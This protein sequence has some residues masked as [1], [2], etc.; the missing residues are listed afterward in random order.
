M[1]FGPAE[2][3][4]AQS[5]GVASIRNGEVIDASGAPVSNAAEKK[6][7]TWLTDLTGTVNQRNQFL[8]AVNESA[9][10]GQILVIDR[11]VRVDVTGGNEIYIP[12]GFKARFIG[13]GRIEGLWDTNP[14][15]IALHSN[16]EISD[17]DVLY[18][19]P[20]LDASINYSASPGQDP[21][22]AV[23]GRM[24]TVM[25]T[26]YGNTFSGAGN[27][28]WYGPHPFMSCFCLMGQAVAK[29]SGKSKFRVA[30]STT[31]DKFI[32]WAIA[33]KGQWRPGVTGITT[34]TSTITPDA[35]VVQ[36]KCYIDSLMLDGVL[37]G[38][39]GEFLTLDIDKTR[40]YRYSD[41]QGA[42]GSNL[43]GAP[44]GNSF[45][46]P[47]LFYIN[48]R[49]DSINITNTIDYGIWV[50][51]N[52][53]PRARR[54]PAVGSCCSLKIGA[55]RGGV[56]G[57]KCF[58]P[59][60][61]ADLLGDVSGYGRSGYTIENFY[62]EYDS[63]ICSSQYPAIR[64]PSG[65][66][67]DTVIRS[68]K[69]V[70]LAAQTT[71]NVLG[72]STDT[73]CKRI[74]IKDVEI[75]MNDFGGTS[76]PGT[77]FAGSDH[78]IDVRYRLKAHTQTQTARGVIAYQGGAGTSIARSR[79]RA[80]VIGWRSFTSDVNGLRN[81]VIMDGGSGGVNGN[82]NVA[83]LVDVTN[84]HTA[85]QSGGFK[86]ERW[87]QS[88]VV[89]CAPGSSITT[90]LKIPANWS[91]VELATG[92]KVALGTTG[93]LTGFTVGWSGTPAGLGSVTGVSTSSRVTSTTTVASTGADR[94]IVITATGGTFDSTGSIDLVFTC[95]L[96]SLG[97]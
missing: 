68:G 47:H 75:E 86:R 91:V 77:Y 17:I 66:Y 5:M 72:S 51:N 38:V 81:R 70:D 35:K 92:P 90:A 29:F 13:N 71:I 18:L 16:F 19:G 73:N 8:T 76:Y 62:A 40:S 7:S 85:T 20:G 94:T 93:G 45:P 32:P 63:T 49:N 11:P 89:P 48:E 55:Q 14:L 34:S 59:D 83:E 6:V 39:Q 67:I 52:V 30:E 87:T 64:F 3:A 44:S 42:D 33:G 1:R 27:A 61:F 28:L 56:N 2:L 22:F 46:P 74:T 9:A 78:S 12:D 25:Q 65:P 60:G 79:H 97:E 10:N 4:M 53:D 88:V 15:F 31:P 69:L 54:P 80:E 95:E 36:P 21:G 41:L 43:G 82:A 24:K 57:Y 58:R 84:G 50:T 26:Q 96:I 37:M 23:Q